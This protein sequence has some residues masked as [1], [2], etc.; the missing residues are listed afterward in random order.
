MYS[1][2]FRD[3]RLMKL[4]SEAWA[5]LTQ[6]IFVH[7]GILSKYHDSFTITCFE[8]VSMFISFLDTVSK[9]INS[10]S[11]GEVT[12]IFSYQNSLQKKM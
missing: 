10:Q 2:L 11:P 1:L 6:A 9:L 4:D 12:S 8:R 5:F 3:G 7:C